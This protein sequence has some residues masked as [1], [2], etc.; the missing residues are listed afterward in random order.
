MINKVAGVQ[1][2]VAKSLRLQDNSLSEV[3]IKN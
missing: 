2:P 1:K 3:A